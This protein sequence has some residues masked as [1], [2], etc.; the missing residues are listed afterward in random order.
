MDCKFGCYYPKRCKF[1]NLDLNERNSSDQTFSSRMVKNISWTMATWLL[2]TPNTFLSELLLEVLSL[3]F[4]Q[5]KV[6]CAN[7]LDLG[8][9]SCKPETP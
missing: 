2:G 5:E 9:S 4:R 7:S 6:L 1:G 3:V 8:L